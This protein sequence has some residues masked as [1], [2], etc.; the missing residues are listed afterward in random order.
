MNDITIELIIETT[1]GESISIIGKPEYI[2]G[3]RAV[4]GDIVYLYTPEELERLG[5]IDTCYMF[6]LPH[7]DI[8]AY[9]NDGFLRLFVNEKLVFMEMRSKIKRIISSID[10]GFNE[11]KLDLCER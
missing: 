10:D 9:T 7:S 1:D 11:Y 2:E 5:N 6:S 4:M 3:T 8:H